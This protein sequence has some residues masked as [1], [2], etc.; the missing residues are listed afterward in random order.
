MNNMSIHDGHRQRL[1]ERFLREGLD[2]FEEYR[3]MDILNQKTDWKTL[4]GVE[5]NL[6]LYIKNIEKKNL[7]KSNL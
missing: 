4:N 2:N 1:K 3:E 6:D 7:Q 5:E